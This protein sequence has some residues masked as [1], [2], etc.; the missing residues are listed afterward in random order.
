MCQT[1][2]RLL[3]SAIIDNY[4]EWRWK[5][6]VVRMGKWFGKRIIS[7]PREFSA[8]RED[9][10]SFGER[11]RLGLAYARTNAV[12][13]YDNLALANAHASF[14][15]C[16]FLNLEEAIDY[17]RAV[18]ALRYYCIYLKRLFPAWIELFSSTPNPSQPYDLYRICIE[19][20]YKEI[21]TRQ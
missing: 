2:E 18:Y 12:I 19:V 6:L 14:G 17:Y 9:K 15:D 13:L 20:Y 10:A 16:Y 7:H 11:I 21:E 4:P 5:P 3:H 1:V 8:F